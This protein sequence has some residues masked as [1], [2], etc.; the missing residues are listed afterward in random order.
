MVEG[1]ID[2]FRK[3]NALLSQ[4]FVMDGKTPIADVVAKAGKDAGASDRAEGLCPL[5]A[6]RRHREGRERLRRRSRGGGGVPEPRASP[7]RRR[8]LRHYL[9]VTSGR[10]GVT[11]ASSTPVQVPH[12]V[13]LAHAPRLRSAPLPSRPR[14]HD[15]PRFKRILLK[16][17]G[18]V[19]MGEGGLGIDPD[20]DRARRRGD[21]GRPRPRAI[22]LCVVVGGGNIFRGLSA[23]GQGLRPRHRR[24]YGHA[25]DR[26]ERARGAERARADRR[27]YPRPVGDPDGQRSASPSSAA[28]PS[29]IWRRAA[30]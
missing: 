27:R 24:L 26:D 1:A 7:S 11:E 23:R 15:A 16:L 29:G 13:P 12:T 10:P 18:E 25:R 19:L 30:S 28:A 8:N 3:E 4:L 6:R 20:R 22:E 17:S 5:P 21:R 2:K 9:A 14:S